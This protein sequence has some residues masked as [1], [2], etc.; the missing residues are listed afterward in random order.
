MNIV[1]NEK[2]KT[3]IF[4]KVIKFKFSITNKKIF[5]FFLFLFQNWFQQILFQNKI[6][7]VLF[8]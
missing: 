1:N 6:P 5:C 7:N 3:I 8:D 4:K 2:N